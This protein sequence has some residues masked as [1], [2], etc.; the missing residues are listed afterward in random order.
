MHFDFGRAVLALALTWQCGDGFYF[1]ERASAWVVEER[2]ERAIDFVDHVAIATIR[3][4]GE[5]TR[6]GA[7]R[8]RRKGGI[9]LS[10]SRFGQIEFI[11][12]DFVQAE[13]CSENQ[14]VV[15]IDIDAMRVRSF[16]A[17]WIGARSL[18][19]YKARGFTKGAIGFNR[20]GSDAAAS[21]VSDENDLARMVG[22]DVTGTGAAG[23][24]LIEE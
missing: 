1:L 13:I 12:E 8:E 10:K 9:V 15:G 3:S 21:I 23:R 4:E 5:V 19:L 22:G 2:C 11:D 24:L 16:L 14:F 20:E 7:G 18:V 6:P 17:L